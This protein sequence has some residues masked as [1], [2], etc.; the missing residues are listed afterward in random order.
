MAT[1]YEN[2]A[3]V[4]GCG[5]IFGGVLYYAYAILLSRDK[6]INADY[7]E[8]AKDI[9]TDVGYDWGTWWVKP[10]V[11]CGFDAAPTN[12]EYMIE[13]FSTEPSWERYTDSDFFHLFYSKNDYIPNGSIVNSLSF[14]NQT[15]IELPLRGA[16]T[17]TNY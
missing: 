3:L 14:A 6:Y 4:Y 1:D 16:I 7:V 15:G 5:N 8:K 17:K 12:E 2:Y 10:S 13:V 9:L 11:E